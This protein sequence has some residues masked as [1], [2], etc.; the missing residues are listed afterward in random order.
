MGQEFRKD[1]AE[2]QVGCWGLDFQD[3][4]FTFMSGVLRAPWPLFCSRP[5]QP[6]LGFSQYVGLRVVTLFNGGWSPKRQEEEVARKVKCC[7]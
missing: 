6:V 2:C 4:C 7:A 1:L 3:G 5:S